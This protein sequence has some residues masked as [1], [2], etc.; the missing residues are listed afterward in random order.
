MDAH[1][2]RLT[3]TEMIQAFTTA[4]VINFSFAP[5]QKP[6]L[7]REFMPNLKS[8]NDSV[9]ESVPAFTEDELIEWHTRIANLAVEM[10][11]GGGP[12]LDELNRKIREEQ[13]A[14]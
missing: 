10:K 5:P 7:P 2:R 13:N 8:D 14:G 1:R 9:A 11:A 4:A 3:H 6:V 12:L